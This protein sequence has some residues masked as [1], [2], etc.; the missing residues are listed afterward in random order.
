[1]AVEWN[2]LTRHAKRAVVESQELAASLGSSSTEPEHLL[3]TLLDDP[4]S[5]AVLVLSLSG[6]RSEDLRCALEERLVQAP[7]SG[8]GVEKPPHSPAVRRMVEQA[9][10]LLEAGPVT[11]GHLLL[12]LAQRGSPLSPL[13][14]ESGADLDELRAVLDA[15]EGHELRAT[16][17][18]A[19]DTPRPP[20][21]APQAPPAPAP[22]AA[23]A[24]E[25]TGE[26]AAAPS[27]SAHTLLALARLV[28]DLAAKASRVASEN[29][30]P[31]LAEQLDKMRTE[32]EAQIRVA[33]PG[34]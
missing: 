18:A 19:P 29:G 13:F 22:T 24:R 1:M 34:R 3:M 2:R 8:A 33:K 27:T 14:E 21:R 28:V 26:Y 23:A 10:S 32:V 16:G 31:A 17:T 7:E 25:P 30:S 15:M 20:V 12:A 11:T 9:A 4:A 5:A 6:G